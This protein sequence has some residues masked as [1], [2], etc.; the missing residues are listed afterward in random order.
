M[1]PNVKSAFEMDET[2]FTLFF[3]FFLFCFFLFF[4]LFFF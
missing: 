3:C 2:R 1:I 4:Y